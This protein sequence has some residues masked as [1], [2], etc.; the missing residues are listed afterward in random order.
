MAYPSHKPQN[1]S[2][3]VFSLVRQRLPSIL[4]NRD[5]RRAVSPYIA[6]AMVLVEP[7]L[8]K[9]QDTEGVVQEIPT[10]VT[11]QYDRS[12]DP[13]AIPAAGGMLG[14]T[15][16]PRGFANSWTLAIDGVTSEQAGTFF[17]QAGTT[18]SIGAAHTELTIAQNTSEENRHA[19]L[20]FTP[21]AGL[22]PV[23]TYY[24][25]IQQLGT[26]PK[27][28][29]IPQQAVSIYEPLGKAIGNL[30]L[31]VSIRNPAEGW[32]LSSIR[33]FTTPGLVHSTRPEMGEVAMEDRGMTFLQ[34]MPQWQSATMAI[35]T[36]IPQGWVS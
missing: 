35:K 11:L 15:V 20:I 21:S 22:F 8:N 3:D 6:S 14:I 33:N 24:F 27:I 1:C 26:D 36:S 28:R 7:F 4:D 5:I 31:G 17:I 9:G 25:V 23:E 18:N 29:V 12:T 19:V 13:L 2:D 16:T 10:G 34:M 30:S 32:Q